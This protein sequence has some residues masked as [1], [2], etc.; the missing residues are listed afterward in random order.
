V[1]SETEG[2]KGSFVTEMVLGWA[3]TAGRR[4]RA[5]PDFDETHW[6]LTNPPIGCGGLISLR[7]HRC[8]WCSSRLVERLRFR[9]DQVSTKEGDLWAVLDDLRRRQ[10]RLPGGD[11]THPW[12]G[13]NLAIKGCSA[14]TLP[15]LAKPVS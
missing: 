11:Y 5:S 13:A 1:P 8:C 4:H 14:D 2:Q 10:V 7:G 12:A 9:V 6:R 15:D 3:L